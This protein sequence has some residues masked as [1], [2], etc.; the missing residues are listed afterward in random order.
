MFILGIMALTQSTV[1]PGALILKILNFKGS[2][3]QRFVYC[4]GLSLVVTYC[5]IVILTIAGL[6][7]QI[8]VL[9][10]FAVQVLFLLRLYW[11]DLGKPVMPVL[12]QF[13]ERLISSLN[14]FIRPLNEDEAP[15]TVKFIQS[16]FNLFFLI[17]AIAVL[18]WA[19]RLILNYLG[20]VFEAWDVINS[21]NPWALTWAGGQVPLYTQ[22]YPQLIPAHWSLTYIFMGST[23]V[24]FFAKALMLCFTF[25]ILLMLMDLGIQTGKGGFLAGC[26]ITYLLLKKFL[27]PQLTNGYVDVAVAFFAFLT[28]YSLVKLLDVQNENQRPTLLVL[29]AVFAG[30]AA[31]VKQTGVYAFLVYFPLVYLGILR[32]LYNGNVQPLLRPMLHASTL[33]T[34]LALPWYI[35]KFVLFQMGLDRPEVQNLMQVS[36][37]EYD[38]VAPTTQFLAALG[39]FEKYIWLFLL[40]L[41]GM[42][43][44]PAFYRWLTILYIL[45]FPLIWSFLA[46]YDTRNLAICLP[47]LGMVSG[48][49]IEAVLLRSAALVA[50]FQTARL[51]VFVIPVILVGT[52]LGANAYFPASRLVEEQGR[53]QWQAFSP[54][55]NEA[56]YEIVAREGPDVRILTNYP[57][58]YL[59][60]LENIRV[61]FGYRDY[62]DFLYRL[63]NPAIEYLLLPR[64]I[65]PQIADYVEQKLASGD[66]ELLFEDRE[67]LYYRMIH[68]IRK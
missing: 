5:G 62:N 20:S 28:V 24:Q 30:G 27:M 8:V 42:F 23:Q 68:M 1:L 46:S 44:L 54:Q 56:I 4:I 35:L 43:L 12:Y 18:W 48:L 17:L 13:W 16:V 65:D 21:W 60:G 15:D 9:V 41:L 58:N 61:D 52:M 57:I 3:I 29:S 32:P 59:P 39:Q 31:M 63:Q 38:A 47:V 64:V 7:N 10:L 6:Y 33:A 11:Q 26:I 37:N 45:P 19:F 66:Y 49:V 50:K 14:T 22:S 55:K 40:I 53:L 67:W 36:A 34:L 51:K 2:F 25:L